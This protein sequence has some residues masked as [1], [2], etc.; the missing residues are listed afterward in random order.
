MAA[1]NS[2]TLFYMQV[3]ADTPVAYLGFLAMGCCLHSRPRA[4]Q[5]LQLGFAPSHLIYPA[6]QST[7]NAAHEQYFGNR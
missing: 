4:M 7:K 5:V 1:S 2:N 6:A 3:T